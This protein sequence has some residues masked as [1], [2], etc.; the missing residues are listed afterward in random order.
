[1]K[2]NLRQNEK[3]AELVD[4]VIEL[5]NTK[6]EMSSLDIMKHIGM[7]SKYFSTFMLAVDSKCLLYEYDKGKHT[8]YG[9][10]KKDLAWIGL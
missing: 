4:K 5:L 3:T 8:V 2:S 7:S 9:L 6:G 10:Y 1:M